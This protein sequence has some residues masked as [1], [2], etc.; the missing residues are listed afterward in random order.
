[1]KI[2]D[3]LTVIFAIIAAFYW[4]RSSKIESPMK[5]IINIQRATTDIASILSNT[6]LVIRSQGQSQ[7]LEEFAKGLS[8]QSRLNAIAATFAGLAASM[9][10]FSLIIKVLS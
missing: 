9:E 10:A 5:F 4:F 3:L 6:P 2:L 7:E 1:M 8:K